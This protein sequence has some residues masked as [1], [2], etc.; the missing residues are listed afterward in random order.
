M[1]DD[2]LVRIRSRLSTAEATLSP[3]GSPTN[4]DDKADALTGSEAF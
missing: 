3:N 1:T 2:M 4:A